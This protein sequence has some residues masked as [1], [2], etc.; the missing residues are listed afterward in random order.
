VL[1]SET[2]I[3]QQ[4]NKINK[5]KQIKANSSH[6]IT[7]RLETRWKRKDKYESPC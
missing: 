4:A 7:V 3:V 2:S 1:S 5:Q 6:R